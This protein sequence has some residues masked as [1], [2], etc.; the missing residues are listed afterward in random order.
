MIPNRDKAKGQALVEFTSNL[1]VRLFIA[2]IESDRHFQDWMT[3]QNS[4]GAAG[5]F[6]PT[7]QLETDRFFESS[8]YV[9]AGTNS[10]KDE[11]L[12]NADGLI[13]ALTLEHLTPSQLKRRPLGDTEKPDD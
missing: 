10:V 8:T 9:H 2:I 5:R 1:I 7:G 6:T 13:V 3:V 12:S 11:A 4:K